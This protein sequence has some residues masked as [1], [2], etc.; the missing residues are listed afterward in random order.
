MPHK[1]YFNTLFISFLLCISPLAGE[2]FIFDLGGVLIDTDP[3]ASLRHIGLKNLAHC[4]IAFKKGPSAI[5]QHIKAKFFETLDNVATTHGYTVSTQDHYA[6]DEHGNILPS[7][8]CLWLAGAIQSDDIRTLALDTIEQSP[9]WFDHRAEKQ[10]IENLISMVFTPEHFIASRKLYSNSI[11]FIKACKKQG[12]KVYV[13]S[14]WDTKSFK[15]LQTKYPHLFDLFDGIVISGESNA[16]KPSPNIYALLLDRYNLDPQKCWFIDDQQENVNAAC[17]IGI[18]GILC[19]HQG[20]IKKPNFRHVS[21]Q[22]S[23]VAKA[24]KNEKEYNSQIGNASR[25]A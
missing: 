18:N 22:I 7:L 12:H 24:L 2:N 3:V 11:G 4:M 14:N 13:L 1:K 17:D 6:Y 20:P 19:T 5:N 15:L 8:M 9:N 25:K 21:Q 16:V 23:S 10:A